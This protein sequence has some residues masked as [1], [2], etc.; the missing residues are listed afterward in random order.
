MAVGQRAMEE[1]VSKRTIRMCY[2]PKNKEWVLWGRGKQLMLAMVSHRAAV[3]SGSGTLGTP[4]SLSSNPYVTEVDNRT[5]HI[6][7]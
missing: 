7:L 5:Y 6:G 3:Q 4:V 1:G 2:C